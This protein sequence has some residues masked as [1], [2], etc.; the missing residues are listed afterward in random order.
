MFI[1]LYVG[2]LGGW[3]CV[4]VNNDKWPYKHYLVSL[5]NTGFTGTNKYPPNTLNPSMAHIYVTKSDV[6]VEQIT[7]VSSTNA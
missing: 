6:H 7:T 5:I 1:V 2:W 3:T 4:C